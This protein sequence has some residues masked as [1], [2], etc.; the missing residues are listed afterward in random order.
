MLDAPALEPHSPVADVLMDIGA[1]AA[2][3]VT[4]ADRTHVQLA[5]VI[6]RGN[7]GDM[8]Q[9]LNAA[10]GLQLTPGPKRSIGG[11]LAFVGTGP[12]SWLA[13]RPS[14]TE[15]LADALRAVLGET[16]AVTDQ[17]SGYTLLRI[18]GPKAR[19][20]FEKGLGVDLHP[21]VFKPNDAA[22]T[23]CAHLGVIIWQVDDAPTYELAVFR[24]L[25]AAFCHWFMQSAAEFG[26]KVLPSG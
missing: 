11:E 15:W 17:S 1:P 10:Y 3:G 2:A 18:S 24:S 22:S 25:A 21:R 13:L 19:A 14:G 6:A 5:T 12:R 9:R 26:V 20:T 4:V 8:T 16:A 23:S 7:V